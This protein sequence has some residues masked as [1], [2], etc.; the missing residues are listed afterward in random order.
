MDD[1]E[2]IASLN[3][4]LQTQDNTP[5]TKLHSFFTNT[6][7]ESILLHNQSQADLMVQ[8]YVGRYFMR[9]G[10]R[11]VVSL[12][13]G[14]LNRR[15]LYPEIKNTLMEMMLVITMATLAYVLVKAA[16]DK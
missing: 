7:R 14:R 15:E 5:I 10:E 8:A 9:S 6:L 12:A 4:H 2:L 1:A 3:T 11:L 13:N 16:E